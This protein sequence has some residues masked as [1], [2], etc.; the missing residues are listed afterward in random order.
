MG[1]NWRNSGQK[2]RLVPVGARRFYLFLKLSGDLLG[3]DGDASLVFWSFKLYLTIDQRIDRVVSADTDVGAW[4]ELR[5]SLSN[6]DCAWLDDFA[7]VL[8]NSQSLRITIAT[9]SR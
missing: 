6:D 4:V 9:V 1:P 5:S 7:A 2:N 8:L 3:V